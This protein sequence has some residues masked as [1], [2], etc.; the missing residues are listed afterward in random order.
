MN[1]KSLPL[2][3]LER[4][5]RYY[6]FYQNLIRSSAADA[7]PPA[8]G[9]FAS[10]CGTFIGGTHPDTGHQYTI[11]EPQLGGWGASR[12]GDG[13]SAMFCGFH[14]ETFN[15]P[16]EINAAKNRLITPERAVEIYRVRV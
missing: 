3:P 10:V 14:A 2:A 11:I 16:A 1:R 15:C 6:C 8:S 7:R 13:N 12:S 9:H 5:F 4:V